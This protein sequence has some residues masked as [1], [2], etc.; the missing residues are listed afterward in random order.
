MV[1][2][3]AS[4]MPTMQRMKY[5]QAASIASGSIDAGLG[6]QAAAKALGLDFLPV[7]SEQYDLLMNFAPHD[8]RMALIIHVLQS[9]EFRSDVEALGGYD[10]KNAGKLIA[11]GSGGA[12]LMDS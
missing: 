5:F 9:P 8:E 2:N 10:L 3:S 6:V 1:P 12:V 7:A 4:A 11:V